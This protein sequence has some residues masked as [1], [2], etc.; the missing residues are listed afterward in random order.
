M[1]TTYR[2]WKAWAGARKVDWLRLTEVVFLA[3]ATIAAAYSA[4]Q[5]RRSADQARES[6]QDARKAAE[7]SRN[8]MAN[9]V[10]FQAR[11]EAQRRYIRASGDLIAALQQVAS[12]TP[13]TGIDLEEPQQLRSITTK[14]LRRIAVVTRKTIPSFIQYQYAVNE[15]RGIWSDSLEQRIAHA[16]EDAREAAACYMEAG[17]PPMFE[18]ELPQKRTNLM[19]FCRKMVARYGNLMNASNDVING[20]LQET[21]A[22]L[23][24]TGA[25]R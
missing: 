21:R 7:S 19:T 4:H 2:R 22:A 20:M 12:E 18:A 9:S 17:S 24:R 6:V 25:E 13:D 23:Q 1:R 15:G 10:L 5:A 11:L 3:L 16:G 14:E 8:Q